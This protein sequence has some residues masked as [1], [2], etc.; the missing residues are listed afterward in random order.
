M[1]TAS[2]WPARAA[3]L[4]LLLALGGALTACTGDTDGSD[5][6]GQAV[7]TTTPG[8]SA[9]PPVPD[10]PVWQQRAQIDTPRDDFA[11]VVVGD[12]IWTF[13]G[14]TGD[15]GTRL[16]STEVYDTTSDTWRY[17]PDLPEGLCSF[18]G[19]AVGRQVYLFGG[20]DEASQPTDFA[21]ALDTRT[22]QWR[23]LPPLP[24]PRYA[25]DVAR[26]GGLIYVMGG[27]DSEGPEAAVD[28]FNPRTGQ[29]SHTAPM[30]DA[31]SSIDLAPVDGRMYVVG[32]WLGAGPTARVQVYD[33]AGDRWRESTPL[34]QPMSRGGAAAVGGRIYVSYHEWSYVYDVATDTWS[35][36]NPMTV[37]RHGLGYIAVGKRIYG[38]GGCTEHPLRDVPFVDVLD[39]SSV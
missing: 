38:I 39:V 3:V 13:G 1:R 34:P 21:A 27:E 36:A 30:P 2:S 29:W 19:A 22:G 9:E 4:A 26:L 23:R 12:E 28:V 5:Q 25:H 15:R 20:L 7:E 18:E 24:H 31:R 11:H 33:P 10:M 8:G 37:P 32:G 6:P 16:S 14:M 17:G 35:R